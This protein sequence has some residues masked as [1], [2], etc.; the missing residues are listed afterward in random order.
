MKLRKYIVT[1]WDSLTGETSNHE[2][3]VEPTT[4]VELLDLLH[5]YVCVMT[6]E[7]PITWSQSGHTSYQ[8]GGNSGSPVAGAAVFRNA[9]HQ[10]STVMFREV[11]TVNS[12]PGMR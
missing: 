10:I 11:A 9:R 5:Q 12:T 3:R 6:G 4:S 2:V 7:D 1:V 8:S